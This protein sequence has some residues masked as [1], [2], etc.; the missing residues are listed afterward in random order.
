MRAIRTGLVVGYG[1]IVMFISTAIKGVYQVYFTNL[2]NHYAVSIETMALV[3]GFFG[4]AQ[5]VYSILVGNLCDRCG[6]GHVLLSGM[7]AAACAFLLFSSSN[8]FMTF[9]LGFLLLAAYAVAALTFVPVSILIDRYVIPERRQF[10]YVLA[11]NGIAAGL[12]ILSPLWIYLDG[13]MSWSMLCAILA[14][15]YACLA[16]VP[17]S[18]SRVEGI[19]TPIKMP[20]KTKVKSAG[21]SLES[22]PSARNIISPLPRYW[23][24]DRRFVLSALAFS[25]C[26]TSMIFIDVH[27]VPAIQEILSH[28]ETANLF[29]GTSLSLLGLA[30]AVGSILIGYLVAKKVSLPLLLCLLYIV[31]CITLMAL[32]LWPEPMMVPLFG[33]FFGITYMGTVIII[34]RLAGSIFGYRHKGFIFGAFFLI[35][36][37]S[38]LLTAWFGGLLRVYCGSYFPVICFVAIWMALSAAASFLLSMLK[39]NGSSGNGGRYQVKYE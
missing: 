38:G 20:V 18:L 39:N 25:G 16:I 23:Y 12:M 2:V 32:A 28:N 10:A 29:T 1:F 21:M 15:V 6:A 35:H 31:R 37:I 5:G 7:L 9:V 36:Q 30:E 27:Y 33:I 19:G 34:S 14:G 22:Q 3:G 24:L 17:A 13:Y 4:L 8:S 26:G 11:T